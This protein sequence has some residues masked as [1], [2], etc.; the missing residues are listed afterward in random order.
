MPGQAG[1]SPKRPEGFDGAAAVTRSLLGY[2]VVAGVF[3]LAVG[4]ILALTRNGFELSRHALSLL[5]LGE[6]GWMQRANLLLTGLM[7]VAAAVGFARA[8][9]GSTSARRTGTLLGIYGV[10]L[11]LSG[12]FPPDPMEGFPPGAATGDASLAGILHLAFGGIG[13]LALAA[14]AVVVGGWFAS[15]DLERWAV[16]SRVAAAG[17][18]VGFLGGAALATHTAG[19][20]L[21]WIAVVIGWAWLAGASVQT[22]R[23]VPHPDPD[24]RDAEPA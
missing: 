20:A 7:T 2:G 11:M 9:R 12:V 6:H 19:V 16:Y 21:L 10:A 13:L 23:T 4:L 22:Y 5:M 18:V 3:Y 14:A 24:R 17:V 8:L 1:G 15:Q